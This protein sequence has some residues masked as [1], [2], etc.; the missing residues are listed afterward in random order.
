MPDVP[1]A[2]LYYG[3]PNMKVNPADI[4]VIQQ[5][6]EDMYAAPYPNNYEDYYGKNQQ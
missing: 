5:R 6:E 2:V 1:P 3:P 4:K